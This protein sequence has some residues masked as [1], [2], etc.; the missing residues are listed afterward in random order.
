MALL[1]VM[2][3]LTLLTGLG[4]ALVVGTMTETAVAAAYRRGVEVFYAADAAAEFAI[5]ELTARTDWDDVLSGAAASGLVDGPPDGT[6]QIGA[7]R[8][9]FA[10]ETAEV[11]ALLNARAMP[12]AGATRLYAYGWF[13]GLLSAPGRVSPMYVCV[14]VAEVVPGEEEPPVRVLY[15]VGRAYGAAG[16]QRTIVATIARR[17][18][19]A[20]PGAVHVR[21][22]EEPR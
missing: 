13:N 7:A 9:D 15:V 18:D 14:W 12:P 4:T 1:T 17:L 16:G 3:A 5:G 19:T 2:M 20:D 6:P 10:D 11:E 22:W 8:I 21:A